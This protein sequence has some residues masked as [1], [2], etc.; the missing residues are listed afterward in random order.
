MSQPIR[1][2]LLIGAETPDLL[3]VA[4][5]LKLMREALMAHAFTSIEEIRPATRAAIES[6]I[7]WLIDVTH[8][9]DVAVLYYSGHGA[10]IDASSRD[11]IPPI[12]ED[13]FY[14]FLIPSDFA[15]STQEDFRGYTNVELSLALADLTRKTK[16]AVVIMDCC[17]AG[18]FYRVHGAAAPALLWQ[19]PNKGPVV[20]YLD[21]DGPWIEFARAHCQRLIAGPTGA[22]CGRAA[23]ANPWAVRLLASAPSGQAY[24]TEVDGNASSQ[25]RRAGVMTYALHRALM[26]ANSELMTWQ[27]IGR[28]MRSTPKPKSVPAQ[29]MSVEGPYRRVLFS[30]AERRTEGEV[31]LESDG[32]DIVMAGGRLVG[33]EPGDRYSLHGYRHRM[34]QVIGH[35]RVTSVSNSTARLQSSAVIDR[36]E[37]SDWARPLEYARPRAAIDL[38]DL[39]LSHAREILR[40]RIEASGY[41]RAL[42]VGEQLNELP[43]VGHIRAHGHSVQLEADGIRFDCPRILDPA[44]APRAALQLAGYLADGA[45]RLARANE[46]IRLG[47]TFPADGAQPKWRLSF[48]R[49]EKGKLGEPLPRTV[50]RGVVSLRETEPFSVSLD[51]AV[52]VYLSVLSIRA[53]ASID[54]LSRSQAGSVEVGPE[55][56]VLGQRTRLPL[57]GIEVKRPSA[58]AI[59]RGGSLPVTLVAVITDTP[60]DL[61]SWEQVGI[62]RFIRPRPLAGE[63]IPR[64]FAT[65]SL[66]LDAPFVH[67]EV[68][69]Y[70]CIA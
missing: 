56:Y 38:S 50:E 63:T 45:W 36:I 21:L 13:A 23:E 14:Q 4:H 40:A 51:T 59:E 37:S 26:S 29:L 65:D 32:D 68:W 58:S 43:I 55:G 48:A 70:D 10:R 57:A 12:G 16:N 47:S 27:D 67:V 42:E 54:I 6:S 7:R 22:R 19:D 8:E 15:E 52:R 69:T 5:D 66:W 41:V 3:G 60:V 64:A 25:P 53:D 34:M 46:L 30:L 33:L 20:R 28:M 2:A 1:R 61:R 11:E 49:V 18:R 31:E 24:E 17:H 44:S 9:N 39:P 62:N 35:A